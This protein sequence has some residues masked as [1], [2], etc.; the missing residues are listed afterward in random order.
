[1]VTCCF[2]GPVTRSRVKRVLITFTITFRSSRDMPV[3]VSTGKKERK[4][5]KPA[6]NPG[7]IS[8]KTN[9]FGRMK[10]IR[11][12]PDIAQFFVLYPLTFHEP[13]DDLL[14]L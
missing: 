8:K 4:T 11:A 6:W 7:K 1:M 13:L 9:L 3:P 14:H 2:A 10:K 12:S 5:I